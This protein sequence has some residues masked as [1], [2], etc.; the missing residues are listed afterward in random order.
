MATQTPS[1]ALQVN[2]VYYQVLEV[3][4]VLGANGEKRFQ[5]TGPIYDLVTASGYS[6]TKPGS[7]LC[8][9][10]VVHQAPD[11]AIAPAAAPAR[12]PAMVKQ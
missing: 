7:L 10:T 12:V 4:P 8:V 3:A 2:S 11:I 1:D 6:Q 9:V 5:I